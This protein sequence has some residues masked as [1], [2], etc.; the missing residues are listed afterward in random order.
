MHTHFARTFA[1]WWLKLI[2]IRAI[3]RTLDKNKN[4]QVC[5]QLATF[6]VN[7]ALHTFTAVC[8]AVALCCC[9]TSQAAIDRYLLPARPTATNP[10]HTATAGK[11]DR[12]M[13]RR[14]TTVL[15]HRPY[16]AYYA[17]CQQLHNNYKQIVFCSYKVVPNL[18]KICRVNF[19]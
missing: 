18:K 9:G 14:T 16:F 11:W 10:L 7:V 19:T 13:N 8:S 4:Q 17:Q 1:T 6:A 5:V 2:A 12:Q 15:L 3:W